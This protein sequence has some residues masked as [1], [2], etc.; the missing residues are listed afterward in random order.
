MRK[1]ELREICKAAD[2]RVKAADGKVWRTMPELR[3]ALLAY[4]SPAA[5]QAGICLM[6]CCM[7]NMCNWNEKVSYI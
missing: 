3:E 1:D 6:V 5:E 4:L 2:L 7:V